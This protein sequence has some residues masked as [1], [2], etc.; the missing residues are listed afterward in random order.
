[1]TIINKYRTKQDRQYTY[2]GT[3]KAL[4]HNHCCRGKQ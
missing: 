1:M 2:N 4:S 3:L